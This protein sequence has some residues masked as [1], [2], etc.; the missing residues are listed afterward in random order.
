LRSATLLLQPK[1]RAWRRQP[2]REAPGPRGLT[3]RDG[4][5]AGDPFQGGRALLVE[6]ICERIQANQALQEALA[7]SMVDRGITSLS[8]LI[9]RASSYTI[10]FG[11]SE[12]TASPPAMSPY[13]VQ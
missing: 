2:S 4:G 13:S 9:Q 1:T 6:P 3:W 8:R 10:S 5:Q 7:F 12:I 11:T